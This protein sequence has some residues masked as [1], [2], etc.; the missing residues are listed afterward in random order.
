MYSVLI[1]YIYYNYIQNEKFKQCKEE[2]GSIFQMILI[3]LNN[4]DSSYFLKYTTNTFFGSRDM[5][6]RSDLI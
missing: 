2:I 1:Y 5:I 4:G 6:Y 3:L